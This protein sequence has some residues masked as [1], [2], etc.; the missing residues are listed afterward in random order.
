MKQILEE[1]AKGDLVVSHNAINNGA[2]KLGVDKPFCLKY[3]WQVALEKLPKDW[4]ASW[5]G[6]QN[7]KMQFWTN[8][9][10][11]FSWHKTE[12]WNALKAIVPSCKD[13]N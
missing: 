6:S 9:S 8:S 13:S 10:M 4:V 12:V 1:S 7:S 3:A 5:Q 11:K 2:C